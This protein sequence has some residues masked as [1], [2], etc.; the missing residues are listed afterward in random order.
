MKT[1][2]LFAF[3]AF[4][5]LLAVSCSSDGDGGGSVDATE[6]FNYTTDGVEKNITDWQAIRS[7]DEFEVMGTNDDGTSMYF[8][9]DIHGNLGRAGSTP[10]N[11]SPDPWMNSFM[12]FTSHYFNFDI[13]AIDEAS[14][15]IKV[16]YSGKLYEDEYDID[17]PFSTVSGSF[18]VHYDMTA[19]MVPNMHFDAKIAGNDWYGINGSMSVYGFSDVHLWQTSGDAWQFDLNINADNY[20]TGTFPFTASSTANRVVLSKYDTT[21][22]EYVDYASAGTLTISEITDYGWTGK[23][24]T[25]T[26]SLTATH[27]SETVQVTNGSFKTL[28][29]P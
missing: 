23:I 21:T 2:K 26:F 13:V 15:M 10:A 27:G 6:Y 16:N 18:N 17:S 12:N 3:I 22:N 1:I 14:Q 25:G 5:S 29:L 24:L 11:D 19:P 7:E 8:N 9:F 20:T 28:Y 4:S